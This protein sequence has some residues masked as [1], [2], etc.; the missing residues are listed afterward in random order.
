MDAIVF[1]W[2]G[3][4]ADT[5]G[6]MYAANVAVMARL[7]LPFDAQRY[8]ASITADWRVM[9]GRLGVPLE[10]IDEA[11]A[12]W[13]AILDRDDAA[14]FPGVRGALERLAAAGHPL[15]LVTAGLSDRVGPQVRRLGLDGMFGSIIYGD[16][17]YADDLP[18]HKPDPA[19]LRRALAD[20][21]CLDRPERSVYVGD[22]PDD[23]RMALAVGTVAV[24]I[25]SIFGNAA[26]LRAAGA[27]EIAASTVEWVERHG[28]TNG[29]RPSPSG[30]T[31]SGSPTPSAG[32]GSASGSAPG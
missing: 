25:E 31:S 23:M 2:D 1:D 3:T 12:H 21:G 16:D 17:R 18:V 13:W 26:E 32:P 20:L 8:R 7:G 24:G 28:A 19:P 10:R 30:T 27:R 15:G 4:L 29:A 11:N 14:L 22:T 6:P 9:Y 5:L